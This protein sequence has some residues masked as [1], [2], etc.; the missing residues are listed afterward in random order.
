MRVLEALPQRGEKKLIAIEWV[1][2]CAPQSV[3]IFW[4]R[5]KSLTQARL[6]PRAVRSAACSL[7]ARYLGPL[8]TTRTNTKYL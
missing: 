7:T 6:E 4:R 5:E 3:R 8:N 2:G 1:A